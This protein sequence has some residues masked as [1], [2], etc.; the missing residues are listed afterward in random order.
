MIDVEKKQRGFNVCIIFRR[1]EN[2]LNLVHGIIQIEIVVPRFG[3]KDVRTQVISIPEPIPK[4]PW[5]QNPVE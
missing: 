1:Q 4:T 3:L 2:W 5:W